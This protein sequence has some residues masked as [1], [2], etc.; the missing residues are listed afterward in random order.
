MQFTFNAWIKGFFYA[1]TVYASSKA[2][3]REIIKA[4]YG[5]YPYHIEKI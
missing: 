4:N 2:D 5:I 1:I 3:A